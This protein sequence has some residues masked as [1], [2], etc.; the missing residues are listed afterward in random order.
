MA[1]RRG[2]T[3]CRSLWADLA[4]TERI[5]CR[6][7]NEGKASECGPLLHQKL[8]LVG[9]VQP[10][11]TGLGAGAGGSHWEAQ[12]S[13]LERGRAPVSWVPVAPSSANGEVSSLPSELHIDVRVHIQVPLMVVPVIVLC[14][15]ECVWA[16]A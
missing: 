1:R 13:S 6:W 15:S 10:L 14:L 7:S 2:K 9:R 4:I 3:R 5:W 11:Q 16:L 8:C 12:G